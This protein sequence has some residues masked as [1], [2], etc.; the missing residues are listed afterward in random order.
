M[1]YVPPGGD[2][3]ALNFAGGIYV[4]PDGNRVAIE[5]SDAEPNPVETQYTFPDSWDSAAVNT[6]AAF[7]WTRYV[8]ATGFASQAFGDQHVWRFH[9]YV[10]PPGFT[11][12]LWGRPT[13]V[14]TL[15]EIAPAGFNSQRFGTVDTRNLNRRI[16]PGGFES[17]SIPGTHWVFHSTRYVQPTGLASQAF[18][19]QKIENLHQF[20]RANGFSAMVV[21]QPTI[22][23]RNRYIYTGNLPPPALLSGHSVWHY[24]RWLRQSGINHQSFGLLRIT[25]G[26]RW[27]YPTGIPVRPVGT[28][29]VSRSPRMLEPVGRDMSGVSVATVGP[30]III[31][32]HGWDSARFLTRITPE[33]QTVYPQ[34][35]TNI[36][37]QTTIWNWL[38]FARPAGFQT[39]IQEQYRWGWN[40]IWNLTQY[41][42]HAYDANDGLSPPPW[43]GW[44]A[45]ANRNRNVA[46]H[47]SAPPA[48]RE[49]LV[50]L[51]ARVI[52]PGGISSS[53]FG[54]T[55]IAPAVRSYQL[56]GIEATAPSHWAVIFNAA[57]VIRPNGTI[58]TAF[59][60]LG[61]E[62][63]RRYFD[64][65]GNWESAVYGRAYIDFA[66]REISFDGRA[67]IRPPFV[68]LPE[69]KLS[70]QYVDGIG[71]DLS[72]YGMTDLFIRW[73]RVTP[74][75]NHQDMFGSAAVRNL[76]PELKVLGRASDEFGNGFLRLQYR[77]APVY[78]FLSTVIPRPIIAD[79]RRTMTVTGFNALRIGDKLAVTK[80]QAP[81]YSRQFVTM[82][83]LANDGIFAG[84]PT[85]NQRS[86]APF[87]INPPTMPNH[88]ATYMGIHIEAGIHSRNFGQP[89]CQLKVRKVQPTG[90]EVDYGYGKPRLSPNTIW[91]TRSITSQATQNNGQIAWRDIGHGPSE[92]VYSGARFGSVRVRTPSIR[93]SVNVRQNSPHTSYGTPSLRLR[94]RYVR[95]P[96]FG[97]SRLGW[98]RIGD[99]LQYAGHFAS[100]NTAEFGRPT[101]TRPPYIG[102]QTVR[103]AGLNAQ[104]FANTNWVSN[105]HRTYQL[106]GFNSLVMGARRAGDTP[107]QWQGLRIGPQVPTI[108]TGFK[109][110]RYG[111]PWVSLRVR[112]LVASGSD[113]LVMDY[114]IN[115][116]HG[117]MTVK[118]SP[119]PAPP[120]AQGVLPVGF[121]SAVM[122][123]DSARNAVH[124]IRPDGN[125]DQ[126]RKGAPDA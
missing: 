111:T 40:D 35:F 39:T 85:M 83:G 13:L 92:F 73:N 78:G 63:N 10:R 26:I 33:S 41:I 93:D 101:L 80:T 89:A 107:Y 118:R 109:I 103:P 27:L 31:H 1:S 55:M 99:T 77:F 12:L 95:P 7:L 87:S 24:T 114:D 8:D 51:G 23:N 69:I 100:S 56:D 120:A 25:H 29:W 57:R 110:D 108:P 34:G 50:W 96:S 46:T 82:M 88:T 22:I 9:G 116:F 81:H 123:L 11:P 48:I 59:G 117:R 54:S 125:S 68:Q 30:K 14:N 60:E 28:A 79:S 6:P 106:V 121:D 47:G 84:R 42:H 71:E 119:P 3:A 15:R 113:F 45:I 20:V 52:N 17:L 38:T 19:L 102:P 74:R 44:T 66:V 5:F 16:Y 86:I 58:M 122:G 67:A 37:G 97:L 90:I 2:K 76:T 49:P 112:E 53:S 64:R 75:W 124:Y 62:S 91:C 126:Y 36:W 104:G 70:R 32:P 98:L 18:G 65:I 115:N 61:I 94:R 105:F 4:A 72:Q 21:G 43:T